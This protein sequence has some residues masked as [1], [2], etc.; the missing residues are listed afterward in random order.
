MANQTTTYGKNTLL[1]RY[2]KANGVSTLSLFLIQSTTSNY[3]TSQAQVDTYTDSEL[4]ILGG[5][6]S[7]SRSSYYNSAALTYSIDSTGLLVCN[8]ITITA[9]SSHSQSIQL[10]GYGILFTQFPAGQ[11]ILF[12]EYDALNAGL[13][14]TTGTTYT[15]T[16]T[17]QLF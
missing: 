8:P 11:D 10:F 12:A 1:Q 2:F 3:F 17:F 9:D 5:A 4:L 7:G 6:S 14:F 16:P 15:V 13:P